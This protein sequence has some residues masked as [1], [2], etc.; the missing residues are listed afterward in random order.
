VKQLFYWLG[1]I[2][3]YFF[4]RKPLVRATVDHVL[5]IKLCCIGDIM[6]TTPLLRALKKDMPRVKI[7]YMVCSWCKE[8]AAADPRVDDVIEFNAY[9]KIGFFG[10]IR[11]V[12]QVLAEIR[13]RKI[14][15]A[16]VL[17]RTPFSGML[18]AWAGIPVRIGFDW[19]NGGF[20]LT[21]RIPFRAEAHEVDRHLDCLAPLDIRPDGIE[22][23]L[24]PPQAADEAAEAFL[25]QY[26]GKQGKGPLIAVFP[27]GGVNPGTVMTTKRWSL[28]GYREVCRDLVERY[29]ARILLV[30]NQGDLN[31]GDMLLAGQTWESRAIRSEG[32]TTL[33][34]L[35]ALLKRCALFIGGDSGPLH[36]ADAVGIPTVSIFGPTDPALL[37][38]RGRQHRVIHKVIPC[39]PCYN[40][41]TVQ[42]GDAT[43]CK[44]KTLACMKAVTPADVLRAVDE[45]LSSSV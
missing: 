17:H 36:L 45:L 4:P 7:T 38:P 39:S 26:S 1:K 25:N 23:E 32:K 28:Q 14:D 34:M 19:E 22:P 3:F 12:I 18:T 37:A 5:V 6:F 8:L 35:A 40:P 44:E 30:G 42:Y 2:V 43:I 9:A 20:G 16:L 33:L 24:M 31:T 13:R 15:L 21:H 10:R 29:D 11:Q 41:I 27:A